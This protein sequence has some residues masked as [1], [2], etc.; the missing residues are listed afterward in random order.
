MQINIDNI[1]VCLKSL[2][3][4]FKVCTCL[5]IKNMKNNRNLRLV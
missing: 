4:F 2:N 3:F 5:L 1:K